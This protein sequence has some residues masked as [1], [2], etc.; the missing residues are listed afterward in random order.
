MTQQD[1]DG[2]DPD[3]PRDR[4]VLPVFPGERP[5]DKTMRCWCKP[6]RDRRDSRMVVH[7]R[8]AA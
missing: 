5:H 1:L 7:S 4:H 3:D 6:R 8:E 2:L